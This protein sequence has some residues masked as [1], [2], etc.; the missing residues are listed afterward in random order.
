MMCDQLKS[1]HYQPT[2]INHHFHGLEVTL[3]M[4]PPLS[5]PPV[6]VDCCY[7]SQ[8]KNPPFAG[9]AAH[10]DAHMVLAWALGGEATNLA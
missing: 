1:I 9:P 10:A 4:P 2:I 3:E 6:V 8:Q 7:A 5:S